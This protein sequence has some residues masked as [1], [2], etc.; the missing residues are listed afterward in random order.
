MLGEPVDRS[1]SVRCWLSVKYCC[2]L[3]FAQPPGEQ[4]GRNLRKP[5]LDLVE[6]L[7]T[8]QQLANDQ[9]RPALA[10]NLGGFRNWAELSVSLGHGIN[11]S[12]IRK[13]LVG[14]TSGTAPV[15]ERIGRSARKLCTGTES[16]AAR[17]PGID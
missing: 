4:R 8:P 10:D 16:R 13:F 2:V 1:L 12:S 6:P 15:L 11:L 9:E 7:A 3:Q 17:E 5:T 14:I